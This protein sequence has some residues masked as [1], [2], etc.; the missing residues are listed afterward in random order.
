MN[1]S[2]TAFFSIQYIVC[3]IYDILYEIN[4]ILFYYFTFAFA[5]FYHQLNNFAFNF[6]FK[7]VDKVFVFVFCFHLLSFLNKIVPIW[8][9]LM[10]HK[11]NTLYSFVNRV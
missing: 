1:L 4:I 3:K 11:N 2:I 5:F 7:F 10:L 9:Y 6:L 8:V